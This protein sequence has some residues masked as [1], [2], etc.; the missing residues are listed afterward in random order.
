MSSLNRPPNIPGNW[1]ESVSEA[2]RIK[3]DKRYGEST[4][5]V[6]GIVREAYG[7]PQ[8]VLIN[9][10]AGTNPQLKFP[11]LKFRAPE[12]G[13]T[14]EDAAKARFEEQTGFKIEGVE[15]KAIMP[16]RSR[17][18]NEWIFR[19]VFAGFVN[20]VDDRIANDGRQAYLCSPGQ[21]RYQSHGRSPGPE[22]VIP[23]GRSKDK[24]PLEWVTP[25]NMII[26]RKARRML[27]DFGYYRKIPC[28]SAQLQDTKSD[29][30]LG[31]GLAVSSMI[32]VY[33]P[34]VGEPEKLI[35]VKR[36]VDKYPGYAGGKIET[37]KTK[38]SL[39]VDP[40]SCA[41]EEGSEELGFKIYPRALIGCA[42]TPLDRPY[43][44]ERVNFY[45]SIINYSFIA[46]PVNVL[47]VEEALRN[48]RNFLEE[49]MECYVVE[50]PD[51]HIDRLRA[52][53]IRMPDNIVI[54]K[55]YYKTNPGDMIPLTQIVSSG[56]K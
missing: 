7:R 33:Q 3:K 54:G 12:R 47:E 21:G 52:G 42:I 27:Y 53:E 46:A 28:F 17:H 40:I 24:T 51:S 26:A 29:G 39:N 22:F 30:E 55:H 45:N 48:P 10:D 37:L 15:L 35:L 18:D 20:D 50:D 19:N 9:S 34:S 23:F 16:T 49:K 38:E 43:G 31:C 44:D 36:K 2:V 11:G 32:V 4:V 6:V 5:S 41:V 25:D 13:K 1:A 14:L 8:F 56:M